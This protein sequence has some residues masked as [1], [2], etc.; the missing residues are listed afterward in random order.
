MVKK[1]IIDL[2]LLNYYKELYIKAE[3]LLEIFGSE[4]KKRGDF[5]Y[6]TLPQANIKPSEESLNNAKLFY[7]HIYN[8]LEN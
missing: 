2:E 5:T 4:K 7:K 6:K 8:L 3:T 1:G